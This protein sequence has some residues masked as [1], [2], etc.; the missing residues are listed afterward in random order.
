MRPSVHGSLRSLFAAALTLIVTLTVTVSHAASANEARLGSADDMAYLR[1][2]AGDVVQAARVRPGERRAGSA[3]NTLGCTLI[4]PGGNYPAFWIRDFAMS[5]DSGW[6]TPDEILNHIR[7]TARAQ[8]G[9]AP[10]V[11][12]NGLVIPPYAIPDHINFDGGAVFYPGTYGT[13]SDQGT[14]AYGF[15]PPVDDHY[16]DRKSVV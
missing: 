3:T 6:I 14:G 8:N 13:G 15:L 7:I 16:E 9:A 12:K 5:V 4:M 2:L 10:R 11:L 1:A